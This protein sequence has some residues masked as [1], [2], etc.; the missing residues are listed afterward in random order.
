MSP[1]SARMLGQEVNKTPQITCEELLEPLRASGVEV[2][3]FAIS[4]ELH[5]NNLK[6][7]TPRKTPLL[8]KRHRNAWLKFVKEHED[9][10]NCYWGNVL[11]TDDNCTTCIKIERSKTFITKTLGGVCFGLP[12]TLWW[13]PVYV[14]LIAE[15]FQLYWN[16]AVHII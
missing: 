4:N 10:D 3:K 11:W 15:A 14:Y 8:L 12:W 9:N 1:T 6:S 16:T 5:R 7:R 13:K 2:T